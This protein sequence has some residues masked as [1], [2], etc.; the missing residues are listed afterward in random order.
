MDR[1]SRVRL[2]LAVLAIVSGLVVLG[3]E[4]GYAEVE[5]LVI[6]FNGGG[7]A[8]LICP[9]HPDR[10]TVSVNLGRPVVLANLTGADATVDIGADAPVAV[11]NGRGVS[12]ELAVG[13]HVLRMVPKCLLLGDI[14]RAVVTVSKGASAPPPTG[15]PGPTPNPTVPNPA[16]SDRPGPGTAPE[17]DRGPDQVPAS[18]TA[19]TGPGPGGPGAAPTGS[20]PG[21]GGFDQTTVE[22]LPVAVGRA[23]DR[24]GSRLLA[25]VAAICAL[26]VTA[27]IIRA[28]VT[29]RAT[30]TSST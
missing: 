29:Y 1:P 2:G 19:S 4:P 18:G 27:G 13:T 12:V 28:I 17:S 9:S 30:R 20:P 7:T 3:I 5:Q 6:T 23:P 11:P 26:G 15:N 24:H 8:P 25:I 21:P 22:V 10:G 16:S 14:G